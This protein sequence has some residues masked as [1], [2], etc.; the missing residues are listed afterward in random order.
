MKKNR[1]FYNGK[2]CTQIDALKG[3]QLIADSMAIS[4][5]TILAV[6]KNL[7]QDHDFASFEQ[8]NLRG[9]LVIPG[10]IDSHTH[11][12]YMANSMGNAWLDG[13]NSIE[14]V[15]AVIKKHCRLIGKNEWV[16]GDGY[17]PD[18]WKKRVR[19]DKFMLDRITGDRPTALFSKDQHTM[20]V[21]SRALKI[22]GITRKT[23]DPDGGVIERLE[24]GE[25]SGVLR[26]KPAY[27]LLDK[28]IVRRQRKR[29]NKLFA[30]AR[31]MAYAKGVTGVHSFDDMPEVLDF[32]D[33]LSRERKLGLRINYYPPAE[34]LSVLKKKKIRYNYGNNYL[35]I[36]GVKIFA[37][38]SLSS[39]SALCFNK[40][41]GSRNN[42]GVETNT[43][44]GITAYIQKAAKLN[45]PCA[46]HGIG[47]R[48][49]A[50]ILDCLER[51]PSLKG[52]A[53]HRI[54]HVQ[55]MR[56]KDISRLKKLGVTVSMQPSHCPSD[57][58]LI[59][60]F[61]GKRGRN[62]FIFK[63]LLQNNIPLTFG[64][65]VPIEPL[66]PIAGID[67]AVNRKAPDSGKVFYPEERLTVSQAVYGF[68][69]GP[70]HAVGQEFERGYLLPGYKADFVILT[71]DIYQIP[72]SRIKQIRVAETWFDGKKVYSLK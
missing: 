60:E 27:S 34:S 4:G 56:R 66:D 25:P 38:G 64:S 62:C 52:A 44:K 63:T 39:Q 7:H 9:R 3:K 35:R 57:M 59:D 58:K 15:L 69:A 54:E 37:D 71:D 42:Y 32:Y 29:A 55:M 6:G 11:F 8:I 22:A 14:E 48:A 26:E 51:A 70:A 19:P 23:K 41:I 43:K 13:L 47:D 28:Y 68:T 33:R 30:D 2:I 21:N 45:L 1:L 5:A 49:V 40:Y 17:S 46:I 36:S 18:R 31:R 65:D 24:N 50:N 10:F 53:R 20:W 16:M 12:A 61:W 67:A 72:R